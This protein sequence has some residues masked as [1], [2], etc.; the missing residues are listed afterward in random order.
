MEGVGDAAKCHEGFAKEVAVTVEALALKGPRKVRGT[1]PHGR[2]QKEERGEEVH[3]QSRSRV[4]YLR[5]LWCLWFTENLPQ[6]SGY[7]LCATP[8][9]RSGELYKEEPKNFLN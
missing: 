6:N 3:S 5:R 9:N 1:W 2:I 8:Y 7:L 4:Q